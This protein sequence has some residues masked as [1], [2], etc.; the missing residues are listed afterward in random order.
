MLVAGIDEVGRGPLAGPVVAAA[1]I[2]DP[3]KMIV[4]LRDSKKLTS[5]RREDLSLQI[6]QQAL[7]WSVGR[8]DVEEIDRMNIHHASLLAMQRAALA[9]TMIPQKIQVDGKFCPLLDCQV[10][11]IIKGDEKILEIS[12]ASII[13]K[14]TRDHEMLRWHQTY[15]E[16]GFDCHVGYGTKQHLAALVKYGA[17]PLHRKTFAPVR[18]VLQRLSEQQ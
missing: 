14:V 8:A 4:G 5:K 3:G 1:V 9:L 17:T 7:A 6:K 12:A 15:P 16:Y 2:L 18:K 11:A 10:E 13:A